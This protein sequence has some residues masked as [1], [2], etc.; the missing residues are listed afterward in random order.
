MIADEVGRSMVAYREFE[1][2]MVV[3]LEVR[4]LIVVTLEQGG[5]R[6]KS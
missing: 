6:P 2:L 5:S 1:Q 4:R 3:V